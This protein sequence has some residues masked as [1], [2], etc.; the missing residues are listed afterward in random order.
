MNVFN[1]IA[2]EDIN[3]VGEILSHQDIAGIDLTE[4]ESSDD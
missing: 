4:E 1:Q 2:I 3:A